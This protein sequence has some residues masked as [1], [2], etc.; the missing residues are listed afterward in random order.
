[1]V[2]HPETLAQAVGLV[3]GRHDLPEP[4]TGR[5][6]QDDL[7]TVGPDALGDRLGPRP[8]LSKMGSLPGRI[9]HAYPRLRARP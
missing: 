4:F 5:G 2:R 1:M 7:C 6:H 9:R 8:R 3:D